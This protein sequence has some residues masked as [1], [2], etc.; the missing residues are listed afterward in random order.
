VAFSPDGR[1]LATGSSDETVR[2]WDPA[3]YAEPLRALC[4]QA[5]GITRDEWAT[6]AAG[7]PPVKVCS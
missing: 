3:L 2:L 7:E 5:G 1:L 4:A 6:Y